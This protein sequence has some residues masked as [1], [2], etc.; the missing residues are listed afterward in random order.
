MHPN[1]VLA[2]PEAQEIKIFCKDCKLAAPL[3]FQWLRVVYLCPSAVSFL[4]S[5]VASF[6]IFDVWGFL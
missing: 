6:I 2:C 4:L 5:F 1:L 3:V